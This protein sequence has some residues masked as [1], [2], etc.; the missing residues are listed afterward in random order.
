MGPGPILLASFYLRPD[1]K[2]TES[3][4]ISVIKLIWEMFISV[5]LRALTV[6]KSYT[7]CFIVLE[8]P[9]KMKLACYLQL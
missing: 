2:A 5:Q 6:N 7:V 4:L 1:Y 3:W 9:Q 8:N